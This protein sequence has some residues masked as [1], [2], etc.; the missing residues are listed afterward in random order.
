MQTWAS[1][2]ACRPRSSSRKPLPHSRRA[3]SKSERASTFNRK[4]PLIRVVSWSETFSAQSLC[5]LRL[6]GELMRKA[7]NRRVAED[8]EVRRELR[9]G[10]HLLDKTVASKRAGSLESV[11]AIFS[12]LAVLASPTLNW[13]ELSV[14]QKMS[15]LPRRIV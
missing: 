14:V 3:V 5:P 4:S 10:H 11:Q 2:T 7:V 12:R 15:E 13:S 9:L 6:C 1:S 8:A